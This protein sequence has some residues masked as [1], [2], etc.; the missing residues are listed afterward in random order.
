MNWHEAVQAMRAGGIVRKQSEMWRK[1]LSDRI[2]ESGAE[3]CY[4]AHAWSADEKPALVFMGAIS[5]CL[6]VPDDDDRKAMD[7]IVVER[8]DGKV[9]EPCAHSSRLRAAA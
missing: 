6:F 9:G 1:Q 4:L 8:K 5:R 7:W 3:G 2:S